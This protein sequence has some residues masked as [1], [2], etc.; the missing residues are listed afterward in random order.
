M[1]VSLDLGVVV[2]EMYVSERGI[3]HQIMS[4]G[5]GFRVDELLFYTLLV[6]GFG[7]V[8]TSGKRRLEEKLSP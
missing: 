8:L 4:T 6:S 7:V 2:G 3:G 5:A 1:I